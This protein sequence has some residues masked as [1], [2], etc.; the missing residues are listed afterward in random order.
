MFSV[1]PAVPG[2]PGSSTPPL[3]TATDD[4]TVPVPAKVPP[5]LTVIA[6]AVL[7][8]LLS[9]SVVPEATLTWLMP[10]KVLLSV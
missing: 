2:V 6:V 7:P 3:L 1:V 4:A 5:L 9:T 8:A 10:V